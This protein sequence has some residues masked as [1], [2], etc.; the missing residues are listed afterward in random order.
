M[1]ARIKMR[2]W[3]YAVLALGASVCPVGA[4]L[5]AAGE[6]ILGV[7]HTGISTVV[8]IVGLGIMRILGE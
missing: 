1:I 3:P 7:D 2:R 8:G 4:F 6:S 5:M